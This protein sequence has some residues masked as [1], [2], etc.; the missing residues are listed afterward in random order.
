[1][2]RGVCVL[3]LGLLFLTVGVGGRSDRDFGA[4][5]A[6]VAPTEITT[7]T[8]SR[9]PKPDGWNKDMSQVTLSARFKAH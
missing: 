1:M 7:A 6:E 2:R 5:Q 4:A 8:L 9:D 3:A